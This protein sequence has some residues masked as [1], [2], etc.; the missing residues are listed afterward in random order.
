MNSSTNNEQDRPAAGTDSAIAVSGATG[1]VGS[2][3]AAALEQDGIRVLRLSRRPGPG[4]VAWDPAR[5]LADPGQLEGVR[6]MVHLAGENIGAGRWTATQKQ[7]IR[8]SRVDGTRNLVRSLGAAKSP[9]RVFVCASAIGFYGDRGDELLDESSPGGTGFLAETCR[10]WEAAAAGATAIGARVVCAR[11]GVV[12]S[13]DGGALQKMLLPFRLGGGGRVGSGR[14]YW[15]WVSLPDVVGALRHAIG[16]ES[17]SGP[18]NVVSPEP[19]TNLAFTK[20]LAGVLRRPAV[21]PMPA[22]LARMALGEMAEELLLASA[23]VLPRKLEASGYEFEFPDLVA[24]LRDALTL[25][26]PA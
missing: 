2:A 25:R 12:L 9:P 13:R 14:Q 20:A 19:A 11:F 17:L 16:T 6:A 1:L 10:E 7:R 24:A 21:I 8:D 23:R 22:A 3:L 26:A 15:S 4:V 18:V 5:G